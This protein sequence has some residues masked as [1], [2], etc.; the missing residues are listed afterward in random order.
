MESRLFLIGV[1]DGI[2]D[3]GPMIG[4]TTGESPGPGLDRLEADHT[5]LPHGNLPFLLG[6][7]LILLRKHGLES[8]EARPCSS[9]NAGT[10]RIWSV[11]MMVPPARTTDSA[12]LFSFLVR[13]QD[14]SQ[15]IPVHE[16]STAPVH[17]R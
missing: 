16:G 5:G 13:L 1:I 7:L 2:L 10:N 17:L 8:L 6:L 15:V 12:L 3:T 4:M 9:D 14:F 11:S